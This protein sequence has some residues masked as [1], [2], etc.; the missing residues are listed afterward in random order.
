MIESI[1]SKISPETKE[2]CRMMA[3]RLEE[4]ISQIK[5]KY[6]LSFSGG[7]DSSILAFLGAK[8]S[9]PFLYSVGVEGSRDLENSR[10]SLREI[11]E[12]L[13]KEIEYFEIKISKE[14][15]RKAL[16]DMKDLGVPNSLVASFE[17]PT[18]FVLKNSER[19]LVISGQ[20]ADELFLGYAKYLKDPRGWERD[21]LKLQ[22]EVVP[23]ED[24]MARSFGKKIFRP[25]LDEK[26]VEAAK[27]IPTSERI[28]EGIR[29]APLRVVAEIL[30]VP[31][32]IILR[33]KKAAQYGS[34]VSKL[35]REISKEL[36]VPFSKILE[37]L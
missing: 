13:G 12:A 6:S 1:L 10:D 5:G 36:G 22:F 8:Y 15:V 19:E 30:G 25:Y 27:K 37:V 9:D 23:F 4:L 20:G 32:K 2:A 3:K 7:L 34:G 26:I 17:V 28:V 33:E 31:R 21:L 29:K 24:R 11:K 14:E 35:M 16:K 18:Y